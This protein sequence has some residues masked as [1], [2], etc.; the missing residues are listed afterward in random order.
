MAD[1]CQLFS[2]EFCFFFVEGGDACPQRLSTGQEVGEEKDLWRN[3]STVL[4]TLGT[5]IGSI[6]RLRMALNLCKQS[7]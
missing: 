2:L 3:K 7:Q 4:E 6:R 5:S 1:R